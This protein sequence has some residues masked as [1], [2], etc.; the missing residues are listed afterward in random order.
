MTTLLQK[1]NTHDILIEPSMIDESNI[2]TSKINLADF[3]D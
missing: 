1:Q 2:D 3:T